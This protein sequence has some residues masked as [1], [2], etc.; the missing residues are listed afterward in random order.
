MPAATRVPPLAATWVRCPSVTPPGTGSSCSVHRLPSGDSH[1][2]GWL[3]LP[4]RLP[5]TAAYPNE[6]DVTSSIQRLADLVPAIIFGFV[7]APRV[8]FFRSGENQVATE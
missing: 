5:P 6:P 4:S 7:P 8:Q 3:P 1:T 2:D